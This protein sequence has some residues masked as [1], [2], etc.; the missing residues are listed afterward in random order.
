MKLPISLLTLTTIAGLVHAA[1]IDQNAYAN[2]V[3]DALNAANLTTL[4]TLLQS[5]PNLVQAL[6]T[7]ASFTVFAPSNAAFDRFLATLNGTQPTSEQVDALLRYHVVPGT[8]RQADLKVEHAV[9][10]TLSQ[11]S[12]LGQN[13]A[14]VNRHSPHCDRH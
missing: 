14:N 5:Q 9:V 8:I 10:P 2:A 3:V 11:A 1:P 6:N 12:G 13:A 7:N 4:A